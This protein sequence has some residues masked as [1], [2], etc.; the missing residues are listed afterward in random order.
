MTR[1]VIIRSVAE[2]DLL[3]AYAWYEK[4]AEELGAD[5]VQCVD[6]VLARFF[7][8]ITGGH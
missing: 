8:G 4:R 5:F 6:D 7:T 3:E 2:R 1:R